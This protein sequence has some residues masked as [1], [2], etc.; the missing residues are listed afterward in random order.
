M[1]SSYCYIQIVLQKSRRLKQKVSA[2]G[3]LRASDCLP[4]GSR[5]NNKPANPFG[6]QLG[7][8]ACDKAFGPTRR[9]QHRPRRGRLRPP[10][11]QAG[12]TRTSSLTQT[13]TTA[14]SARVAAG[15]THLHRLR[16]IVNLKTKPANF[17][18]A[19]QLRSARRTASWQLR[20][21]TAC[22]TSIASRRSTL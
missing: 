16:P 19:P 21:S 11:A 1:A 9:H 7:P 6:R 3:P 22:D 12:A 4:S 5:R 15:V 10:S 14:P 20:P 17:G 2:Q 13:K 8:E 18:A